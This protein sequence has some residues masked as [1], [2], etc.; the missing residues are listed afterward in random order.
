M[1]EIGV[2]DQG[3][4]RIKI[5]YN[6]TS[7]IGAPHQ[8]PSLCKDG[9]HINTATPSQY[10]T[11][12]SLADRGRCYADGHWT[13]TGFNTML[14]PNSASCRSDGAAFHLSGVMS[15]GSYHQGGAHVLMADGAVKFVTDSIDAGNSQSI[16]VSS[17][18]GSYLAAGSKS[19]YGIWGAA[20]T[21]GAKET[22]TLD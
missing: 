13:Y 16:S 22:T 9:T 15:A 5:G 11:S 8:N 20:G 14:P 6:V 1:G 4:S 18:G 10:A 12:A 19:P 2:A 17:S 21:R 3:G 7:G